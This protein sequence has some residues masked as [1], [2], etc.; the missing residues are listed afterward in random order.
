MVIK[1][2]NLVEK[3]FFD[4][5]F[6][7]SDEGIWI[8]ELAKPLSVY[9]PIKKQRKH[10]LQYAHLAHCNGSFAR[11]CGVSHPEEIIGVRLPTF[12]NCPG[13][14]NDGLTRFLRAGYRIK[15]V[16]IRE[17]DKTGKT[18][19]WLVSVTG[20]LN[21]RRLVRIWGKQVDITVQKLD[22]AAQKSI[23]E[24]VSTEKRLIWEMTLRGC[25]LKE[26]SDAIGSSVKT[27]QTLRARLMRQVGVKNLP[28]LILLGARLGLDSDTKG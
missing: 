28:A 12:F 13:D 1:Q 11:M 22:E 27:V 14:S 24:T 3:D 15:N 2:R 4:L 17:T 16:E 25:A 18:C 6:L 20:V 26:I 10:I 21:G 9:L 7:H 5:F 8:V 23:L 19:C